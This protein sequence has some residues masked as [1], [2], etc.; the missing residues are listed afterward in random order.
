L[1]GDIHAIPGD[2]GGAVFSTSG[3]IGMNVGSI[4]FSCNPDDDVIMCAAHFKVV[5]CMVR[6]TDLLYG[7][8]VCFS[9]FLNNF[10][11]R[12]LICKKFFLVC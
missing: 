7:I 9:S 12:F 1:L 11:K 3:L 6:S 4:R 8:N 5:N 10:E 2:S